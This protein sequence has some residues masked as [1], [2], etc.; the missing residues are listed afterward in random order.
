M[1]AYD[2]NDDQVYHRLKCEV[3]KR[4][5]L[6]KK[7]ILYKKDNDALPNSINAYFDL[8]T[9]IT[10]SLIHTFAYYSYGNGS[11]IDNDEIKQ[12]LFYDLEESLNIYFKDFIFFDSGTNWYEAK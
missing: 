9:E 1:A 2:R 5:E 12:S 7:Y 10:D 6:V 11:V 8:I 3:E 4:M